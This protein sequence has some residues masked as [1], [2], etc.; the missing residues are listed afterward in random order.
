MWNRL[1]RLV[2]CRL[3]VEAVVWLAGRFENKANAIHARFYVVWV[4]YLDSAQSGGG[5]FFRHG[6]QCQERNPRGG[7][8]AA[9]H[10]F[11]G[12]VVHGE[13]SRCYTCRR[14]HSGETTRHRE[15]GNGP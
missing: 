4:L 2:R 15:R 12:D 11:T 13:T 1:V 10:V 7:K 8:L 3:K 5:A 9:L 14:A 6:G